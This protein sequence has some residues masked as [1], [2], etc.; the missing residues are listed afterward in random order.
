MTHAG[1]GILRCGV[2]QFSNEK[3]A[4]SPALIDSAVVGDRDC[5]DHS[6]IPET[7]LADD[8]DSILS[9]EIKF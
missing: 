5:E 9:A 6:F 2:A 3:D 1:S 8:Y 7:I 4:G